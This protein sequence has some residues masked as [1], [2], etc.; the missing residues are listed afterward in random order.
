MCGLYVEP[1]T[2]ESFVVITGGKYIF[3]IKSSTELYSVT[4]GTFEYA[5]DYFPSSKVFG[6]S[7]V[8]V[9]LVNFWPPKE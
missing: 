4:N 2:K 3:S 6:G 7:V 8:Q 5:E 9:S 1:E